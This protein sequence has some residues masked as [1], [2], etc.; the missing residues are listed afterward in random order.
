MGGK[1]GGGRWGGKGGCHSL[2]SFFYDLNE[3]TYV[4]KVDPKIQNTKISLSTN[5]RVLKFDAS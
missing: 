4:A 2:Y 1:R 5:F 3:I